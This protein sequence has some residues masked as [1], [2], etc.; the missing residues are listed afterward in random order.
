MV[1]LWFI[2]VSVIISLISIIYVYF[3]SKA[4]IL[5]SSSQFGEILSDN[6][7]NFITLNAYN[8]QN[9]WVNQLIIETEQIY[10]TIIIYQAIVWLSNAFV[11]FWYYFFTGFLIYYTGK[12]Y[13][14]EKLTYD[15]VLN[16]FYGIATTLPL[17]VYSLR[18]IKN[19][20]K[21]KESI[22]QLYKLTHLQTEINPEIECQYDY[23]KFLGKI[24]FNNV[25]FYY[26]INPS[27]HVLQNINLT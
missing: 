9:F 14:N 6:L 25:S 10:K 19:I 5:I 13:V 2:A 27:Y 15:D 18:Y 12:Q 3:S 21:M 11:L 7:H 26:P 23:N 4:E 8:G 24:E 1:L 16:A 20:S 17:Y 22:K